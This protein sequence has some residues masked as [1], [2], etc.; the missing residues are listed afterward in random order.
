MIL[1]TNVNVFPEPGPAIIKSGPL[2]WFIAICCAEFADD[3]IP[4]L[5]K[6]LLL[7]LVEYR[8]SYLGILTASQRSIEHNQESLDQ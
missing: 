1:S 3:M 8:F 6:L 4:C 2:W 7:K 5:L